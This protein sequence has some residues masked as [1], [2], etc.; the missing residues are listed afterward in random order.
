MRKLVAAA[1]LVLAA[2]SDAAGPDAHV[3]SFTL[4]S[5]NGQGLPQIVE[6]DASR[7]LEVTGGVVTLHSDG[8]FTDRLDFR[9]TTATTVDTDSDVLTGFYTI[10]GDNVTFDSDDGTTYSMARSGRRLT[11]VEPG[12]TLVYER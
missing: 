10:T 9:E 7:T 4:V 2:C 3:G 5:F 6:Q 11:L 12:L 1:M 8:T